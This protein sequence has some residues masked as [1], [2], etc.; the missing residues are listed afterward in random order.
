MSLP[1]LNTPVETGSNLYYA[2]QVGVTGTEAVTIGHQYFVP[3]RFDN[4]AT[5]LNI[6]VE[7]TATVAN[8]VARIG[9][10][11]STSLNGPRPGELITEG[12]STVAV[13]AAAFQEVAFSTNALVIPKPGLYWLSVAVQ[14]AAGTLRTSSAVEQAGVHIPVSAS[15]PSAQGV[16]CGYRQASITSALADVGAA[17]E[18]ESVTE[19]PWIYFQVD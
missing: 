7:A 19:V 11:K 18:L 10:Y 16:G 6:G 13:A 3:F 12:D 2:T 17:V 14:V 9:V 8:A 4:K 15:E 5:I 1:Y